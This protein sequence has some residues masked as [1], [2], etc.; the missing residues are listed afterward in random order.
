MK[1]SGLLAIHA[2]L[3]P[4]ASVCFDE[5]ESVRPHGRHG[6]DI[7]IVCHSPQLI[8][9]KNSGQ[10]EECTNRPKN[11]RSWDTVG[12]EYVLFVLR[13]PTFTDL[14]QGA[15]TLNDPSPTTSYHDR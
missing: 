4:G 15:V 2:Y 5:S 14:E 3:E 11:V 6:E 7:S 1:A 13:E 10:A 8:V 9:Q 12:K